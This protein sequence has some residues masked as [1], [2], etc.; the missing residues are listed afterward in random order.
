MFGRLEKS[1]KPLV[2]LVGVLSPGQA[3]VCA[4]SQVT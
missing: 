3:T 4:E 2:N 1:G